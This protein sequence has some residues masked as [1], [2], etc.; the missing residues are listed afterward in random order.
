V[1][2]PGQIAAAKQGLQLLGLRKKGLHL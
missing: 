1:Q 2:R